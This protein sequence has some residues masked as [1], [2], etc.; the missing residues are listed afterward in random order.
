[1]ASCVSKI[2]FHIQ[3]SLN[4]CIQ[5]SVNVGK[6]MHVRLVAQCC[7][8]EKLSVFKLVMSLRFLTLENAGKEHVDITEPKSYGSTT[9]I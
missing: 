6:I 7:Y 4:S 9:N 5:V 2:T 8:C 1:M 3:S